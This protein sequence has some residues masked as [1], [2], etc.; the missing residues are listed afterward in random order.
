MCYISCKM[1]HLDEKDNVKVICLFWFNRL[2]AKIATIE[3]Y[4]YRLNELKL[5]VLCEMSR[6]NIG[7][8]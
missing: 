5:N 3:K 7:I 1:L 8:F 6:E 4:Y 2:L